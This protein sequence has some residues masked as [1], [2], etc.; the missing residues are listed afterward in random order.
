MSSLTPPVD[1]L[2]EGGIVVTMDASRRIFNPGYV[3]IRS[4]KIIEVGVGSSAAYTPSERLDA[5]GTVVLPGLVNAHNHLDQS[6]Y[7]SCTDEIPRSRDRLL[8]LARSLTRERARVAARL[9]L[10][11]QVQ[12]GVTTTH[13]SHWTHYYPDSTD[14]ILQAIQESHMR[15]IVARS[16]SDNEETPPDFRERVPDV[17]ADLDRLEREY[18]SDLIQIIS[19]PTTMMRCTP[20]AVVAMHDWAKRRNKI[21]HIHLAQNAE[22]LAHAQQTHGMGSVQ[23]AEQ[24][25]VLEPEMLAAHCGG[26]LPQEVD[27]MGHR[28]IRLAHCPDTIIRGGSQ[29]PPIWQLQ[30]QGVVVGIGTDGSATNNGQNPWEAMKLAVY[31]QR[32][33]F[34]DR[35]LGS[36]E[37]AL[38]LATIH[39]AHALNLQDRVGSLTPGNEADLALFRL[40]QPHLTPEAMLV[41]NLVYSGLSNRADTV[42]VGGQ[43]VLRNGHS[44]VMDENQV[45]A[46]ARQAQREIL[47]E[48]GLASTIGLTRSWQVISEP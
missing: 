26:I 30:E 4:G 7:R 9:T 37:Q 14:G 5:T 23:Y 34:G 35:T 46:D 43:V 10:L 27:L 22:E 3:A 29:V 18:D 19:E 17:L 15:A 40:D 20:E 38:E 45:I 6:L 21:W 28:A 48:A 24:L 2:I 8:Q 16:I 42:L 41:S 13:E 36:A 25:G 31:L 12:Y 39:S 44:T 33:R 32:I 1:L 11:E 47:D